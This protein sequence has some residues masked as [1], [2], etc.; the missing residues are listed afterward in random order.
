MHTTSQLD[1][2][3][4]HSAH[5]TTTIYREIAVAKN[6]SLGSR[7]IRFSLA[8]GLAVGTT[9]AVLALTYAPAAG[10]GKGHAHLL[11][12]ML[13]CNALLSLF[14][15]WML[16]ARKLVARVNNLASAMDRGAEGDLTVTVTDESSDELG[17]LTDNFNAMFG[18]LAGTVTRVKEAVEELRAIS[19]T[20]KDAVERGLDTAEVQTGAVQRTTDGI[21][22]ID[23]SVNEVAQSVESLSRTAS[24]NAA[25][26]VQMSTSIEVVAEHM[27]GLAREV[28]EVSSS[29]IQ[30]AAA[31]KEIGRSVGVLMEDA[32]RTA[33]L[34]AE[35]DLSIKQVE[36]SAL[37][38]AAISEEVL[39]DAE[40]GR[41]SVD[42]TISGISEIRR[43]SRSASDTIT[44]LSHRVGDIGTIIS[45]I[46]EIAEQTKLLAL[47]ASIIAAQAGE[48]GKGFA[49]VANEIKELAKRTTSSTGEIADIISGLREE[50]VRAVQA[51][52]QAEDRIG[53]G[54]TLSYR[55]GE[56]LE[57]IVD[58]VKMAADQ[59][60]EIARTTVEQAQGSENMRRAIERVA[61]MVG[62]IVRA[63]Q[64]QAHGTELITEAADRMK[65]L[66][67]RVFTSTRE[68]RDTSTHIVRSSEGVTRMI[69]TIR[70]ASQVQAENS[71]KIVEAVENMETTAVNGLDTTR[72]MEEAVSRLA[73][74]AEGLTE[75]MAG[76]KVR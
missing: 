23:R 7:L 41:D 29:I 65:S 8:A 37:E 2:S 15:L 33:S 49:V 46:N 61:E 45:V 16:S 22:A 35:L 60:G 54:E 18:R 40:L 1:V 32:S 72:L 44:T 27:E 52:K 26:I 55:S 57:K 31:E 68:Q 6:L 38:T 71:Q 75:A 25:A 62:Q 12:G 63:T 64:E 14:A 5:L 11:A 59:V 67:G 20:V 3:R 10:Y 66:T 69:S 56:A 4:Q 58:G 73:R 47:N 28:D 76:F 51:I 13:G 30:M 19:A 39:R 9:G 48:H 36:K 24:E 34:V 43:S 74:Q 70:Q 53:E 17:L 21:R 42:R 50:T